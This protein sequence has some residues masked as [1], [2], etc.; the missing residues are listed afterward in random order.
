[1]IIVFDIVLR[2]VEVIVKFP[3]IHGIVEII[4]NSLIQAVSH[5]SLCID[6]ATVTSNVVDTATPVVQIIV[7][8]LIQFKFVI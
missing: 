4:E 3:S 2:V 1:M 7:H 8:I 5:V 6:S